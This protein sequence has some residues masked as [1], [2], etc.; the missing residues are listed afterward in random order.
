MLRRNYSG[1]HELL[2]SRSV[3]TAS[4]LELFERRVLCRLT[5]INRLYERSKLIVEGVGGHGEAWREL[6]QYSV[7][8]DY[9]MQKISTIK[10][11]DA[12]DWHGQFSPNCGPLAIWEIL[13]EAL[14]DFIERYE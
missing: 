7:Q 10:V 4:E 13:A 12:R 3:E 2:R 11:M 9:L 1:M 8:R 6:R 14:E 5:R